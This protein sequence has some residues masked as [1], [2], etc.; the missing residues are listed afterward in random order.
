MKQW[1]RASF[2]IF[3]LKFQIGSQGGMEIDEQKLTKPNMNLNFQFFFLFLSLNAQKRKGCVQYAYGLRGIKHVIC[4]VYKH[5]VLNMQWKNMY[6]KTHSK[7]FQI[8]NRNTGIFLSLLHDSTVNST[9]SCV[10]SNSCSIFVHFPFC[11]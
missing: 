4:S 6:S 3:I 9:I 2:L 8:G 5:D 11:C 7:E 10:K 1:I